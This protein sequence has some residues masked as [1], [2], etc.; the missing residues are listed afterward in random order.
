MKG[1]KGEHGRPGNHVSL[2]CV[3]FYVEDLQNMGTNGGHDNAS[4]H[5]FGS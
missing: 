4:F 1:E 2:I 3:L 5:K